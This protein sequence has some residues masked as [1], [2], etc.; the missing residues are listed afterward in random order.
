MHG[1]YSFDGFPCDIRFIEIRAI[2]VVVVTYRRSY[3]VVQEVALFI[4]K[5]AR[6]KF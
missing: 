5:M 2:A 4:N 1:P 6:P 3:F